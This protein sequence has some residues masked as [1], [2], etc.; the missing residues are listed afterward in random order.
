ME[1]EL[2]VYMVLT[3]KA[4]GAVSMVNATFMPGL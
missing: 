4:Q 3:R 2:L 1:L